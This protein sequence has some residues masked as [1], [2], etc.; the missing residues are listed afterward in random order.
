MVHIISALALLVVVPAIVAMVQ[1]GKDKAVSS[2][3]I[4]TLILG[5]IFVMW[6]YLPFLNAQLL[7]NRG[8]GSAWYKLAG[9][10]LAVV[11]VL[12]IVKLRNRVVGTFICS[13]ACLIGLI[14]V[15]IVDI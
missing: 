11:G 15:N 1:E 12:D 10:G 13:G 14:A 4:V 6:P 2:L 3:C 5:A 7:P 9:V 8:P